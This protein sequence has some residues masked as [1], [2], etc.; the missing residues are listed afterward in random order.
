VVELA[1]ALDDVAARFGPAHAVVAHSLG[2]MAT[3][4]AM[5]H[6]WLGVR[7]LALVAPMLDVATALDVFTAALGVGPR[8]RK[9]LERR[10]ARW[11]GM[12]IEEFSPEALVSAGIPTFVA[13]D[14]GD[15]Q[16]PYDDSAVFVS[17][18]QAATLLSTSGL[19]H[20]RILRD[21][22]VVKAVA[23]HVVD[24]AQ[25]VMSVEVDLAS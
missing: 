12:P 25:D 23:A 15:R 20:Q 9:R 3:M 13:H 2:A 21:Q 5:E 14:H 24:E 6:G 8:T 17:R 4:L 11:V 22:D 1:R 18:H 16:S 7:R 10:I 19:G